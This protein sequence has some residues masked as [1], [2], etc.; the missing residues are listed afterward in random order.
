[1]IVRVQLYVPAIVS[2]GSSDPPHTQNG[3]LWSSKGPWEKT[4]AILYITRVRNTTPPNPRTPYTF[5]FSMGLCSELANTGTCSQLDCQWSHDTS[6]FCADCNVLCLGRDQLNSHLQGRKHQKV[7]QD[8]A[9]AS[10]HFCS[11]CNTIIGLTPTVQAQHLEG[12][13]HRKKV[14]AA[15]GTA[16]VNGGSPN[17]ETWCDMCS[18]CLPTRQVAEAHRESSMH[19]KR[20]RLAEVGGRIKR[21]QESKHGVLVSHDSG[22]VD[23]PFVEVELISEGFSRTTEIKITA[24]GPH[25]RLVS[26]RFLSSGTAVG[27]QSS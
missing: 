10:G 13:R 17:P 5:T 22:I 6:L 11:I 21:S 12:K 15:L 1:M 26:A 19:K 3:K 4:M 27:S 20:V 9:S 18:V 14:R 8:R 2:V 25:C 7:V 16:V 23:M 24:S